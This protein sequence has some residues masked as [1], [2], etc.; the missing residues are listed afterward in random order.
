MC[1][2]NRKLEEE[3]KKIAERLQKIEMK[4]IEKE[5]EEYEKAW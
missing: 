1:L 3:D 5:I 4:D 2:D